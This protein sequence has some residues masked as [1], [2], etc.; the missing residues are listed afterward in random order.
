MPNLAVNGTLR[1]QAGFAP[2]TS[3]VES[4]LSKTLTVAF[5]PGAV[6]RASGKQS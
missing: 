2:S 3:N 6:Y 5:G 4:S 1:Q